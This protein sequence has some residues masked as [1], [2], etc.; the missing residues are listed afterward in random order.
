MTL[1]IRKINKIIIYSHGYPQH[2]LLPGTAKS[3]CDLSGYTASFIRKRA[4]QNNSKTRY[5]DVVCA[6]ANTATARKT[7]KIQMFLLKP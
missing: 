2:L 7:I 4:R 1:L 3:R 5:S 6:V